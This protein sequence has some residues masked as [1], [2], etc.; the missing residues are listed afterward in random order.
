[1]QSDIEIAQAATLRRIVDLAGERAGIPEGALEPY[2]RYKAKLSLDYIASLGVNGEK[3][4]ATAEQRTASR[5]FAL[6]FAGYAASVTP[7]PNPRC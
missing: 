2:G 1:M 3:H 5:L 7:L 4:G 6:R